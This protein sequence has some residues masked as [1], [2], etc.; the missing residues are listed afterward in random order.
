MKKKVTLDKK[1]FKGKKIVVF[2]IGELGGGVSSIKFLVANGAH[3]IATDIKSKEVLKKS[4]KEIKDLKNVTLVLGQHRSED[5]I[6][7]DMI[8]KTPGCSW[9]N[10]YI[11]LALKNEIQVETDAS[12]FFRLCKNRIIGITG[13]KGKTTVSHM[14]S[15]FLKSSGYHAIQI[16]VG[17]TPVLDR[18]ELLKKNSIVVFELSSWRLSAIKFSKISP[19]VSIFTSFFPDHMNYYKNMEEYWNDKKQIFKYQKKDD[20]FVFNSDDE[21]IIKKINDLDLNMNKIAV[22]IKNDKNSGIFVEDGIAFLNKDDEMIEIAKLSNMNVIGEHNK[23]NIL[24]AMGAVASIGGNISKLRRAVK[25]FSPVKYRL[26]HIRT[27][28]K[29]EYYNDTAATNP[30]AALMALNSFKNKNIILLAGGS[31]KN[32]GTMEFVN[33]IVKNVKKV[34]FLK[35]KYSEKLISEIKKLKIYNDITNYKMYDSMYSII[36]DAKELSSE[37]DIILLSPG[38]SSFSMFKNEFERGDEFVIE[39]EKLKK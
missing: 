22:S 9:N 25:F 26:E 8:I 4:L 3:V 31:D 18:L 5:F 30:T 23:R 11:K 1:W 24:L 20:T 36:K 39:V 13:S 28:N 38:A 16:G 17:V 10:E 34:L 14:V 27:L 7:A 37:N 29:V 19:T 21:N 15:H 35:G 32:L 33:K 2:G 12:L 6:H